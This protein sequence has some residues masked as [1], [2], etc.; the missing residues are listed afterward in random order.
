MVGRPSAPSLRLHGEELPT[1]SIHLS[2]SNPD[3]GAEI[4]DFFSRLNAA[5]WKA[6]TGV[7]FGSNDSDESA[8]SKEDSA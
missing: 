7:S 8:E 3:R 4:V 6:P 2:P 1:K 5:R